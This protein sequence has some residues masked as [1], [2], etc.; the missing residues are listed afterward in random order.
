VIVRRL[1]ADRGLPEHLAMH[2][3]PAPFIYSA[4]RSRLRVAF[5]IGDLEG[6]Y[7][8]PIPKYRGQKISYRDANN[9]KA[10][11]KTEVH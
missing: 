9:E 8:P 2:L 6:L 3:A 1:D 4:R 5:R 7:H 11:G 10:K